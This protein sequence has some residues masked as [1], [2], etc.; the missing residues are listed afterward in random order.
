MAKK[1]I[2]VYLL[3]LAVSIFT[4]SL[5]TSVSSLSAPI[6]SSLTLGLMGDLGL[7]RVITQTARTKN[8]FSWSF[9][10]L[11]SWLSQNDLNLA[12][13]ES[14]IIKNC[15][16]LPLTTF[17]FCGDARFLPEL[18]KHHFFFNLA[19]NHILNFG[20]VGLNQ[21]KDF[22]SAS[23]IPFVYSHLAATEF[24][25]QTI[26]NINLGFIGFDLTGG[27]SFN[28]Q[29]ILDLVAKYDSQVDWLIVSLHWGAEYLPHPE[30]WRIDF[31][32]QLIDRGADI[33]HGHHPHVWQE[34]ETYKDRLI[35]YSFGNFIFDQNWSYN[36]S[37]SNIVRLTL[38]RD[39]II[40]QETFPI[41]IQQ[42]S[43]P[44]LL[45]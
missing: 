38:S 26:N 8:D 24:S 12:N 42:N 1:S 30:T 33:I 4:F 37:H 20:Q 23:S 35:F 2:L 21:S 13:L 22:L 3:L 16:S 41:E 34:P 9:S 43:R 31:A 18:Q 17:T 45:D 40:S 25:R 19:N 44:I 36:T 15:P 10:G 29:H 6:P 39:K 7:G 28:P 32:H 14:P 27:H 5:F 11:S